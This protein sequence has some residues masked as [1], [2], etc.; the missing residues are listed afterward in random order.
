MTRR[1]SLVTELSW[2]DK[3]LRAHW[4]KLGGVGLVESEHEIGGKLCC[5]RR[6]FIVSAGITSADAFAHAVRAHWGVEAMHWVLDVTFREDAQQTAERSLAD[7]LSWLRK[8][9]ISLLK[10]GM[11]KGE[12][13]VGR[14]QMSGWNPDYLKQ[15]L[16]G[17]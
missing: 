12:S 14:M 10:R 4:K 3:A 11:K 2:M 1:A 5:E 8:F 9:A 17:Q 15:V 13:I 16:T 6:Y 7:N